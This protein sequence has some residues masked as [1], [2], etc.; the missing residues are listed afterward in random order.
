M[1][2]LPGGD[3]YSLLQGVGSFDERT[4]K[5]YTLEILQAL[6]Y[7]R[8][9]G[10]VH[11]DLKPDNVLISSSGKIR[12][13]DFGL[14]HLGL[15]DRQ[16]SSTQNDENNPPKSSENTNQ[17]QR[18]HRQTLTKTKV[19]VN[20]NSNT[21]T[22]INND[23]H[24]S[25]G[26][27]TNII[28]TPDYIAPEILMNNP[29]N[30]TADYWS[31][32]CMLFEF[33]I[34]IPPFHAATEN[35][36]FKNILTGKM[37]SFEDPDV[38]PEE[39][40]IEISSEV[41]DL[42]SKLLEPNPRKRLG[43]NS[44]DEILHHPWFSEFESVDI[45]TI[46]PPF[47]PQLKA[48]DD[49]EYFM[50][51]YAFTGKNDEDILEDIA[52]EFDE[53]EENNDNDNRISL[54]KKP[55]RRSGS[56][57]RFE[58]PGFSEIDNDA[59]KSRHKHHKHHRK[60]RKEEPKSLVPTDKP[61]AILKEKRRRSSQSTHS[62]SSSRKS[63][64]ELLNQFQA[65][66]I[67][68][69]MKKNEEVAKERSTKRRPLPASNSHGNMSSFSAQSLVPPSLLDRNEGSNHSVHFKP[70]DDDG[71][72]E[73]SND[74]TSRRLN[75]S[76]NSL[77]SSSAG[78]LLTDSYILRNGQVNTSI[79]N[80][81]EPPSPTLSTS[82]VMN[83]STNSLLNSNE[84]FDQSNDSSK[85]DPNLEAKPRQRKKVN[86]AVRKFILNNASVR[87]DVNENQIEYRRRLR[88][89][90]LSLISDSIF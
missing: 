88:D 85:R 63:K 5:I 54:V 26:I 21:I 36:T 58:G 64:E 3:L 27:V 66:G 78:N 65:V 15:V 25:A 89:Q 59:G 52:V 69:I 72:S 60:H 80:P 20:S 17:Q 68:Q 83:E 42:I 30:Y 11:R 16:T 18:S 49:T 73:S 77:S 4:A 31:L 8:K 23:D 90:R 82:I 57:P 75:S 50:Q 13:A 12:L 35:E 22:I 29:H 87:I 39:E 10:I 71:S 43:F 6:I 46:D 9:N 14:S 34:G 47:K 38:D 7:L 81:E 62:P 24:S 41:K 2:Y 51:R 33:L 37:L 61:Q 48:A 55:R 67:D 45:D 1:E 86:C 28:G 53:S 79:L 76:S 84:S 19:D 74:N 56:I 40:T 70:V 32:G 44:I